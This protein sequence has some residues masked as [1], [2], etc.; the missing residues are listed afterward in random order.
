MSFTELPATAA[1]A[2]R[3]ARSGFEVAYPRR[4]RGG[5]SINGCTTAVEAGQAW[6]VEYDLTIDPSWATR[7]AQVTARTAAG[8]RSVLLE[9]DGPGHWLIDGSA[10]RHL[11]GCLDVDLE[12][13]AST[14]TLPVHRL[15]L[16]VGGAASAPAV[17]VRATD[18]AVERLE[19]HYRRIA[20]DGGHQ[21][22]EY[23]APALD[24]ACR[25]VFDDSGLV[26]SYPGIATRVA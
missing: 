17:Y 24:F 21:C 5:Y 4:D 22:Y 11:D 7:A 18:L 16:P 8:R 2:H 1:W 26:L 6:F 9:T 15:A 14:N 23:A 25:L 3:D 10:A 12:S 20:D 19:Q 13:S